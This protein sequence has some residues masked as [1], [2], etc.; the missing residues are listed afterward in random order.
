MEGL[1][2]RYGRLYGPGSGADT[3][4][5]P[6]AVHV[7][8]AAYAALLAIDHGEPGVFN[9]ADLNDEVSTVKAR[10]ELGWRADFRM[11]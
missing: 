8:A 6:P 4:P 10:A 2:L 3:P 1:A 11:D 5:S 7:D 9:I